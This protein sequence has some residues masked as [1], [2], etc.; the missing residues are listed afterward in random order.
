M[1]R[2]SEPTSHS[3]F[4]RRRR[5]V[6]S[7][8]IEV[9]VAIVLIG[10][11]VLPILAAVRAS[12]R[13]SSISSESAEI[14]TLLVNAIDRVSRAPSGCDYTPYAAAAVEIFGW[15]VDGLDV[16]QWYLE[17]D[18]AWAAGEDDWEACPTDSERPPEGQA[19]KIRITVTSDTGQVSRSIEV[20]KS[21]RA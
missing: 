2:D 21:D 13:A 19:Q 14:E 7:T 6:G 17:A 9:L 16:E 11:V 20:V 3:G 5:D 18:G 12:I 8:F 1:R 4:G 15:S 10:L